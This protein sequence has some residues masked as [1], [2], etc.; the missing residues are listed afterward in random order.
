MGLEQIRPSWLV[1]AGAVA[2]LAC[3]KS[4]T[5][6]RTFAGTNL[7]LPV[8]S[9]EST[10]KVALGIQLLAELALD[11]FSKASYPINTE[12]RNSLLPKQRQY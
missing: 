9:Q 5:G 7:Q 10:I 6:S 4:V 8:V 12:N 2:L 3:G 11:S 1:P